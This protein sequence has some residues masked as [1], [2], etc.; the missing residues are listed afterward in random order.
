MR[1]LAIYEECEPFIGSS[2]MYRQSKQLSFLHSPCF[3]ARLQRE[4]NV[5]LLTP[6]QLAYVLLSFSTGFL[7]NTG[8]F[9]QDPK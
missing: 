2:S 1:V 5:I 4:Q 8:L 3:P 9:E 7:R 6:F